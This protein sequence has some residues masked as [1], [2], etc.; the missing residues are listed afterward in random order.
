[1]KKTG[2]LCLAAIVAP[3]ALAQERASPTNSVSMERNAR[4]ARD[5]GEWDKT[6][7]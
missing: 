4:P 6:Y 3:L 5:G 2:F 7:K 1:M